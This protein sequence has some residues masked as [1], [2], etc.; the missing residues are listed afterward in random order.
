M[1]KIESPRIPLAEQ[2]Q[3]EQSLGEQLNTVQ[4]EARMVLPGIQ[5]LFGFQ[6]IVVFSDRFKSSLSADEQLAHLAALLLIALAVILVLTPTAYHRQASHQISEHFVKL[7]SS[8]LA[9]AML[10]LAIGT[11]IDIFIVSRVIAESTV[12]ASVVGLLFAILFIGLWLI[13]PRNHG[14]LVEMLPL[15]KQVTE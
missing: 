8:F 3:F 7:S 4:Q 14:K 12:W 10:P 1:A 5:T 15:A 9:W 2:K 6:L 13:L 11:W